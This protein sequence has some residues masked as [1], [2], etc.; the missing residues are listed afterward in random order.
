MSANGANFFTLKAELESAFQELDIDRICQVNDRITGL[1]SQG[2]LSSEFIATHQQEVTEL[3]RLIRESET[4]LNSV[5][6]EIKTLQSD[7]SKKRKSSKK[8]TDVG[9][10]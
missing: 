3:Y 2:G 5:R 10:L 4:L 8:Y 6:A 9:K 1:I 7:V